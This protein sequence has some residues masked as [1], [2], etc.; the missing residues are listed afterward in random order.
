MKSIYS[1]EINKD[2]YNKILLD[3]LKETK[4]KPMFRNGGQLIKMNK[5]KFNLFYM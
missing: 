5:N 1:F 3:K 2:I 4:S